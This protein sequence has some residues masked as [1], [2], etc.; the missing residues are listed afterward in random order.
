MSSTQT[1]E[2][3]GIG[4]ESGQHVIE[5]ID[6]HVKGWKRTRCLTHGR[7][8]LGIDHDDDQRVA[9]WAARECRRFQCMPFAPQ[10][11][12]IAPSLTPANEG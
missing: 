12:E 9:L 7:E 11:H 10:P 3:K 8:D 2:V 5:V 1:V 4:S 6:Y